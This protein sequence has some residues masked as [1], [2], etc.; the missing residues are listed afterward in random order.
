LSSI[1]V[2]VEA[3]AEIEIET[4]QTDVNE[5]RKIG[6]TLNFDFLALW[7]WFAVC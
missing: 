7:L 2:E 5:L 3:E 1:E 4:R 6:R